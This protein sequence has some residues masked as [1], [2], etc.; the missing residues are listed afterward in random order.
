MKKRNAAVGNNMCRIL[1]PPGKAAFVH[2][3]SGDMFST[4]VQERYV[5]MHVIKGTAW[6]TQAGDPQDYIVSRGDGFISDRRG[7]VVVWAMSDAVV[8]I[9]NNRSVKKAHIMTLPIRGKRY[10]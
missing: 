5:E 2:L 6:I 7:L 10:S 9:R 8:D 3:S 1:V 4:E